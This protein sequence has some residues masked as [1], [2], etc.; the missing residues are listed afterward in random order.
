MGKKSTRIHYL[1]FLTTAGFVITSP[2]PMSEFSEPPA[3]I[4]TQQPETR[5]YKYC[6]STEPFAK[7][8]MFVYLTLWK[9][10]IVILG[11]TKSVYCFPAKEEQHHSS[12]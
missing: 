8:E 12:I 3:N 7:V 5:I 10:K 2:Y 1:Y 4:F 6:S 9:N 11:W